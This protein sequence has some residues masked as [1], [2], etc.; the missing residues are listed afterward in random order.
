MVLVDQNPIMF[1]TSVFKNVEFGL[2]IRRIPK[3][4]RVKIVT[5]ALD[6]VGMRHFAQ[7]QAQ[8]LSA[9]ET[10]RVALARGLV[11]SP[12]VLFVR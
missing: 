4:E 8:N 5:E 1:T 9:G 6:M 3:N 11:V 12:Q 7:A 2:R 10:Q